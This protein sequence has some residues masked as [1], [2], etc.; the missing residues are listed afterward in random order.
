MTGFLVVL[1]LLL[2][3]IFWMVSI[4]NQLVT[5]KGRYQNGF[6]QIEVQLKRRYDLTCVNLAQRKHSRGYPCR[7]I[8]PAPFAVQNEGQQK[9]DDAREVVWHFVEVK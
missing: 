2:L 7:H 3:I 5:L 1:G 8:N 6:A 9:P 4:Y